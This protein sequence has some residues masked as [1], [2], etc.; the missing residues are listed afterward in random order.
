MLGLR[1]ADG[2]G[3]GLREVFLTGGL[4]PVGKPP[5]QVY[6][7]T[8]RTLIQRNKAYYAKFPEDVATVHRLAAYIT[9]Q[10]NAVA[11]PG[12]GTL[13]VHR[14]LASGIS[15]GAHGGLDDVHALILHLKTDLDTLGF[16][17]RAALTR[18]ENFSSFDTNVIYAILHEAI[19][20]HGPG[21]VSNWAAFRVGKGLPSFR[22]LDE[23]AQIPAGEPM[24]FSGEM[25]FPFL[26][27]TFPGLERLRHVAIRLAH[28]DGWPMLYDEFQLRQNTVPVY[29]ASF[30]HD[31]Y[32]DF[33]LARETAAKIRGCKVFETNIMYHNAVRAKT[34]EVWEALMQLRQDTID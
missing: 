17:S 24:F 2:G 13:T 33:G 30:V 3:Q 14:L 31:M 18:V 25:I 15:F 4:A 34:A 16:F 9:S 22:W 5:E 26:F 19:Y 29:A 10:N 28:Y 1:R 23:H 7:A 20:C 11:L 32:V 6:E 12:G 8:F 21:I 27:Q